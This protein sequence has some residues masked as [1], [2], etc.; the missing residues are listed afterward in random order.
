MNIRVETAAGFGGEQEPL[1]FW[2]GRRRVGVRLVVDRW[3][4]PTRRWLKVDAD[5]GQM[6]V[7]RLDQATG[8]WELA[9]LTR[10]DDGTSGT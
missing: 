10:A 1:A 6:Y 3:F 8:Q 2:L 9:A 7:L 4:S 5:D